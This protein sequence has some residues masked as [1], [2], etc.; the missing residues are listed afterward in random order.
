MAAGGAG[1]RS[2]IAEGI[3]NGGRR[4]GVDVILGVTDRLMASSRG[5]LQIA[6][7]DDAG[8]CERLTTNGIL[9]AGESWCRGI[10]RCATRSSSREP[11]A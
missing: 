6:H 10:S 5:R 7:A 8:C 9:F 3:V 1:H 11:A 2:A 4:D